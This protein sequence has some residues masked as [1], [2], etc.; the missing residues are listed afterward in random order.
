M[1]HS[2]SFAT[3]PQCGTRLADAP[4]LRTDHAGEHVFRFAPGHATCGSTVESL[5]GAARAAVRAAHRPGA[6]QVEREPHDQSA[7]SAENYQVVVL[8]LAL[9]GYES[10][11]G[12]DIWR[13]PATGM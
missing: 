13:S 11:P 5:Q 1:R 9:V 4:G 7:K 6:G 3:W 2:S 10:H 8:A 12:K